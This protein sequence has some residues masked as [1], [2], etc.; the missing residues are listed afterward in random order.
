[1]LTLHPTPP[2]YQPLLCI[3]VEP[4]HFFLLF[5]FRSPKDYS[6]VG[7]WNKFK[8]LKRLDNETL[9]RFLFAEKKQ[10]TG[11]VGRAEIICSIFFLAAFI[12]YT[13]A[14]RRKKS[15]GNDWQIDVIMRASKVNFFHSQ[16][17]GTYSCRLVLWQQR[18]CAKSKASPFAAYVRFMKFSWCRR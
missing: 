3:V 4:T 2:L 8:V 18:C 16:A 11:V 6:D 10:V 13:K 1:M 9:S 14:T 15:T 17:G 12:F 5:L 7:A